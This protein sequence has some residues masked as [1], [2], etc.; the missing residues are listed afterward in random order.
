MIEKLDEP[1]R[2]K[3]SFPRT[4]LHRIQRLFKAFPA[5]SEA[6]DSNPVK[7]IERAVLNLIDEEEQKQIARISALRE[8]ER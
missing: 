1:K 2:Y 4:F 5:I 8:R 3:P 7:F 6:Y